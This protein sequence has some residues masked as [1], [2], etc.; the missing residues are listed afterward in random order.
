MKADPKVDYFFQELA[1]QWPHKAE[2]ILTGA[3]AGHLLKSHRPTQDVDFEIHFLEDQGKRQLFVKAIRRVE[4]DTGLAAQ[5][6]ED[7]ERWSMISLLEY[8][9]HKKFYKNFGS[10]SVYFLDIFHWSIGKISRGLDTDYRDL[11][12][13]FTKGQPDPKKLAQTWN[14]AVRNSP[15]SEAPGKLL[16]QAQYFFKTYGPQIWKDLAINEMLALLNS[17]KIG[18][19]R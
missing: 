3:V 15:L 9:K 17:E 12:V 10:I 18:R 5:Y 6:A 14:K 4:M 13:A 19:N 8:R 7:I 1:R 2:V 16:K 11:T